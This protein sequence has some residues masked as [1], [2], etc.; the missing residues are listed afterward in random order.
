MDGSQD[1]GVDAG[2]ARWVPQPIVYVVGRPIM[3]HAEDPAFPVPEL[4]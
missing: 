4:V 2:V 1:R 3:A